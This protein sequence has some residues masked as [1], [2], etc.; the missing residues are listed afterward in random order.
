MVKCFCTQKYA[1]VAQWIEQ[2]TSKLKAVGS[3][4]T[5]GTI[6][7]QASAVSSAES[8]QDCTMFYVYILRCDNQSFYVGLTDNLK[9]RIFQHQNKQSLHTKRY[10]K[11]EC[12]YIEQFA[13]RLNAEKREQQLK[14][15]SRAKKEALI[16]EEKN[17]LIELSKSKSW[18]AEG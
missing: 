17:K 18:V 2:E 5:R 9:R 13:K 15:W 10:S 16:N 12:V 8:A 1:P 11:V 4:P 6:L 14:K 3:N 7:R